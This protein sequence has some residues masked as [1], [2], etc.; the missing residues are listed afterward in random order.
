MNITVKP[1]QKE[2][3][4]FVLDLIEFMGKHFSAYFDKTRVAGGNEGVSIR[5]RRAVSESEL[6]ITTDRLDPIF[7]L[8]GIQW[9]FR[10]SLA[11]KEELFARMLS[12]LVG[13][14]TDKITVVYGYSGEARLGGFRCRGAPDAEALNAFKDAHPDCDRLTMKV[15]TEPEST[16]SLP[17]T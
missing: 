3:N 9:R 14:F 2:I 1:T 12:D 6:E 11:S 10:H 8:G 16:I 15:W 13:V 7:E 17:G 4:E 5:I